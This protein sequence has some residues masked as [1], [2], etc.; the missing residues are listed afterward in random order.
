MDRG[1]KNL[2]LGSRLDALL[3]E[4]DDIDDE[5]EETFDYAEFARQRYME[6]DQESEPELAD[7]KTPEPKELEPQ[8]P[9]VEQP[10]NSVNEKGTPSLAEPV[11]SP[12]PALE[13][14]APSPTEK[15]PTSAHEESPVI[16][17]PAPAR[18]EPP[19]DESLRQEM[20]EELGIEPPSPSKAVASQVSAKKP[21]KKAMLEMAQANQ[22]YERQMDL[23]IGTKTKGTATVDSFLALLD[24]TGD[25]RP[26]NTTSSPPTSPG[27]PKRSGKTH[28]VLL[29]SPPTAQRLASF[30]RQSVDHTANNDNSDLE[31]VPETTKQRTSKPLRQMLSFSRVTA[32]DP[33]TK[34]P[35]K[36]LLATLQDQLR[37]Q[38]IST[39]AAKIKELQE[40]GV[41]IR[42][43]EETAKQNEEVETLLE[44]EQRI[45]NELR[46][47]EKG[48]AEAAFDDSDVE[49]G[50]V[51]DS[52]HEDEED[53]HFSG[54][55]ENSDGE[56]SV[57]DTEETGARRLAILSDSEDEDEDEDARSPR[58]PG[59]TAKP[60]LAAPICLGRRAEPEATQVIAEPNADVLKRMK[61]QAEL[62]QAAQN[63][64]ASESE[65]SLSDLSDE[66][67]DMA[68]Q[69]QPN[70]RGEP[71]LDDLKGTTMSNSQEMS[72]LRRRYERA[73]AND[74]TM[75]FVEDEAQES[76]DEWAGLGG[77][78]DDDIDGSDIEGL[79]DDSKVKLGEKE[80]RQLHLEKEKER[81][82][83]LVNQLVDD[84]HGGFRKKRAGRG[85]LEGFSD[86]ESDDGET[87]RLRR[88]AREKRKRAKML[89]E[90]SAVAKLAANQRTR[91]F[92]ETMAEDI[93]LRPQRQAPLAK[94]NAAS[95][96][97]TLQ[98]LRAD[99]EP[100]T[101][102]LPD[103]S[104]VQ[105]LPRTSISVRSGRRLSSALRT[106]T[107]WAA[108]IAGSETGIKS[109]EIVRSLHA[110]AQPK[111]RRG[112]TL[113]APSVPA[114][115]PIVTASKAADRLF[116][117]NWS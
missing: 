65:A 62:I 67:E 14:A 64:S 28:N 8:T 45:A 48:D 53:L 41:E 85:L 50:E 88:D 103:L 89:E 10:E 58:A 116:Q 2:P 105:A 32:T 52:D 73:H 66:D 47:L 37:K 63:A 54:S 101:D 15:T 23:E 19:S 83:E 49:I 94:L 115:K 70:Q 7:P 111:P 30:V 17:A 21:T 102:D 104:A 87:F 100:T 80:L 117:R 20:Y 96:Q 68:P 112:P 35:V 22:R 84:V 81:D 90:S 77:R 82:L 3:R 34:L 9:A 33:T 106:E 114:R 57:E 91:A 5:P 43:S 113:V 109:V 92:V 29:S 6:S 78:S 93:S 86:E 42:S 97:E 99:N 60:L 4:I 44:R 61:Q 107:T 69:A 12:I 18:L 46:L 71:N 79:V 1:I 24:D 31:I 72:E 51:A 95:V 26:L 110:A 76:D 55:D 108:R 16:H 59:L 36:P 11:D 74:L 38:T 25:E 98:F 56:S 39:R 27:T 13:V 75:P 40:R